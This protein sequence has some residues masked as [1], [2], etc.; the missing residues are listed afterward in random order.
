MLRLFELVDGNPRR[1]RTTFKRIFNIGIIY[2]HP[3]RLITTWVI[4]RCF[5]TF[6]IPFMDLSS[7]TMFCNLI[8]RML[9]CTINRWICQYHFRALERSHGFVCSGSV[10]DNSD[11]FSLNLGLLRI[12]LIARI[13]NL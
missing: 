10:I 9:N 6:S 8:V 1:V 2:A 12:T 3:S 4:F 7:F 13:E 5:T 11:F